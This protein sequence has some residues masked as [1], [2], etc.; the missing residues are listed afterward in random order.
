MSDLVR[1]VYAAFGDD[2]N[3]N[4]VPRL[5]DDAEYF[6]ETA[7][8][9]KKTMPYCFVSNCMKQPHGHGRLC[10]AHEKQLQRKGRLQ[11][12]GS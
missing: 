11:A 7:G 2:E 5:P 6:Y 10:G 4:P 12:A 8:R 3:G 1:R 9:R